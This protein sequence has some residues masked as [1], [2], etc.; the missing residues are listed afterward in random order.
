MGWAPPEAC[1]GKGLRSLLWVRQ[2][3]FE[4]SCWRRARCPHPD[5]PLDMCLGSLDSRGIV[6]LKCQ[7]DSGYSSLVSGTFTEHNTREVK[8]LSTASPHTNGLADGQ[9]IEVTREP[10]GDRCRDRLHCV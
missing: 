8:R 1:L 7:E 5:Q 3:D 6:C 2:D 10:C 9:G 4:L